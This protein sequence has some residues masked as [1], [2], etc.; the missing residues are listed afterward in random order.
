MVIRSFK[1]QRKKRALHGLAIYLQLKRKIN[2]SRSIEGSN[3]HLVVCQQLN[4]STF[5]LSTKKKESI[6][7]KNKGNPFLYYY[8]FCLVSIVFSLM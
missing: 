6:F 4:P 3:A 1:F 7:K 2:I 5:I 8:P